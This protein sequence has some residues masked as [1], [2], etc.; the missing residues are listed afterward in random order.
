MTVPLVFVGFFAIAYTMCS[1]WMNNFFSDIRTQ[2]VGRYRSGEFDVQRIKK[3]N[4][5][6]DP[7]PFEPSPFLE[8]KINSIDDRA[9]ILIERFKFLGLLSF[10][11]AT[12]GTFAAAVIFGFISSDYNG[13]ILSGIVVVF[14]LF[15]LATETALGRFLEELDAKKDKKQEENKKSYGI[16]IHLIV[17]VL[18]TVL[19]PLAL[20]VQEDILSDQSHTSQT[21]EMLPDQEGFME[22][23][24]SIMKGVWITV[25]S[26]PM[27]LFAW[28]L[29]DIVTS[30][31]RKTLEDE[32][33][34]LS[35]LVRIKHLFSW[36]FSI[37]LALIVLEVE[38]DGLGI[39]GGLLAAGLSVAMRDSIGNFI[40]G[41]QMM[42]DRSLKAGDVISIPQSISTDTGSTY[43]IVK[44]I[45]SRYTII[46]DRNTV[47]RLVP[48]SV[49]VSETIEHWTHN[50][51]SV[52][53]SLPIGISYVKDLQQ[54]RQAKQI[55]EAVCY[56]VPR[57]LATKPPN[58]LLTGYGESELTF[59]L[60]FW[61]DDAHAGIRPVISEVL[62]SLYERLE[63]AGIKI[64]FPQQDIHIKDIAPLT[65]E[66][67]DTDVA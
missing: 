61:I 56:D 38:L 3:R 63:E 32:E 66:R 12:L 49:I 33:L 4:H 23:A 53:L 16:S 52:R 6:F 35:S 50:D 8:E 43:G 60:R 39:F 2:I 42:W 37:I 46:E 44:E 67:I 64:P 41:M 31:R 48:N 29:A 10:Y 34:G 14:G 13:R 7:F 5:S 30:F 11:F 59:S 51:R 27:V 24:D 45:R 1:V 26:F 9:S 58:A 15:F 19:V 18:V 25:L 47:R 57:V 21:A 40:A 65:I 17:F 55:M 62:I 54:V 28:Y 20:W 36:L 22:R